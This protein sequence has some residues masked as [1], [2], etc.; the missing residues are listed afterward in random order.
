M[1]P[2]EAEAVEAPEEE[3]QSDQTRA[4]ILKGGAW[5][6]LQSV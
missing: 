4:V 6:R 1:L 2:T 5:E 3:P